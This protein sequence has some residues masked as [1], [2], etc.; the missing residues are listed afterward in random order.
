MYNNYI[1]VIWE[2]EENTWTVAVRNYK[3]KEQSIEKLEDFIE[4]ACKEVMNKSL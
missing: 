3:T 2:E 4:R 1:L